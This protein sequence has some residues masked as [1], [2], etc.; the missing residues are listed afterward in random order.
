MTLE[1]L[2]TRL[3]ARV[4]RVVRELRAMPEAPIPDAPPVERQPFNP[5]ARYPFFFME[6]DWKVQRDA[7][8]RDVLQVESDLNPEERDWHAARLERARR[9]G[10][11][12]TA[13]G[14]AALVELEL[15]DLVASTA[16]DIEVAVRDIIAPEYQDA[17]LSRGELADQWRWSLKTKTGLLLL[18]AGD[19]FIGFAVPRGVSPGEVPPIDVARWIAPRLTQCANNGRE[20]RPSRIGAVSVENAKFSEAIHL[21]T[22]EKHGRLPGYALLHPDEDGAVIMVVSGHQVAL[23]LAERAAQAITPRPFT[24]ALVSVDNA[25]V[26]AVESLAGVHP[27]NLREGASV[28][29][30]ARQPGMPTAW[31]FFWDDGKKFQLELQLDDPSSPFL[32]IGRQ[33]GDAAVRELV[34]LFFFA[35]AN[36]S[37]PGEW[38]WWP[39][40]HLELVGLA[41][42]KE[43][44]A[45]VAAR[46]SR[47]Q[48]TRLE[49]HFETG[50]P[51]V[52]PLVGHRM[53][54]GTAR[55]LALHDALYAG[56]RR[57]DGTYGNYWWPVPLAQLRLNATG[58]AGRAHVLSVVAGSLFR[59]NLTKPYAS[60][61]AGRLTDRLGI[62]RRNDRDT[63]TRA[64]RELRQT[65][66]TGQAAGMV[67]RVECE[68][69]SNPRAVVRLYPG[70]EA[71]RVAAG[72]APHRPTQLPATGADLDQWV[73]EARI[74]LRDATEMLELPYSTLRRAIG[75]GERPL[76]T[77]VRA[78]LRR[79]LWRTPATAP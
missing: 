1:A 11:W 25:T 57:P 32:A 41:R 46:M 77:N 54:D 22:A 19:S 18:V 59:A 12:V 71:L 21:S 35:W 40:E 33:Y 56:V 42:N 61:T 72:A 8:A 76:P 68:D 43:N 31:T 5:E 23:Y 3:K 60:I 63:D 65:L 69:F 51:L 10:K 67:S 34:A 36:G 14:M 58:S 20:A 7:L 6:E 9:N 66:D 13:K 78:A 38:W 17:V 53:T 55:K 49:A 73:R 37:R 79:R 75:Y 29:K 15:E 4:L 27:A 39:D 74:T 26:L 47:L 2:K 70:E 24:S 44:R 16:R 48:N 45:A 30:L 64:A 62:A 50:K 28:E 52:G